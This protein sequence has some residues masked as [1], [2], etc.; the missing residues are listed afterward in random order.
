MAPNANGYRLA[1]EAEWEYIARG[2][3]GGIPETQTTYSGS[4]NIDDVGW[5]WDWD[6]T[7]SS[8]MGA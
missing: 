5:C 6:G 2:G 7:I 1:T 8:D 4:T 3:D